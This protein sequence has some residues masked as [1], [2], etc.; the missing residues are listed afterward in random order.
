MK[1]ID[2]LVEL[3]A[4]FYVLNGINESVFLSDNNTGNFKNVIILPDYI[5]PQIIE[6]DET[7]GVLIGGEY[8]YY[9]MEAVIKG[10][11]VIVNG[12][13]FFSKVDKLILTEN[14]RSQVFMFSSI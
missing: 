4:Y 11:V 5:I 7:F 2:G 13:Q 1:K 12:Q 10:T 6:Q 8:A 14:D 9:A 3:K